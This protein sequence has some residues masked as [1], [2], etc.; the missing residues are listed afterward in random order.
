MQ[1]VEKQEDDD[2]TSNLEAQR[3]SDTD[4]SQGLAGKR[5][6]CNKIRFIIALARVSLTHTLCEVQASRFLVAQL[7]R[8]T[9]QA[10]LQ[11]KAGP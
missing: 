1:G 4:F 7:S 10:Q 3:K 8:T 2:E 11:S 5:W 9:S 6:R